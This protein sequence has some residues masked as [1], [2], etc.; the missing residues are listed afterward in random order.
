MK[1]GPG[2]QTLMSVLELRGGAGCTD[3]H[4]SF[5]AA[6]W[7]G[8]TPFARVAHSGYVR[9]LRITLQ[10]RW[11]G[12][13]HST[14]AGWISLSDQT[15]VGSRASLIRRLNARFTVQCNTKRNCPRF[16]SEYGK[17]DSM[18]AGPRF[19]DSS[20][21]GPYASLAGNIDAAGNFDR[22][23]GVPNWKHR[24]E[25]QTLAVRPRVPARL[26][27]PTV[28]EA[29]VSRKHRDHMKA[30]AKSRVAVLHSP[31]SV[32]R[33]VIQVLK[34]C[35]ACVKSVELMCWHAPATLPV[36]CLCPGAQW[37]ARVAA[38]TARSGGAFLRN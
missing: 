19:G 36:P 37:N 17:V 7:M 11:L 16:L 23:T 30:S 31:S 10:V 32:N 26:L 4:V 25:K 18:C 22:A 14:G 2:A 28:A 33:C 8:V 5:R 20:A 35:A 29:C 38:I 21:P 13:S 24:P 6:W 15:W 12:C 27:L 9:G 34:Q 1:A 3:A